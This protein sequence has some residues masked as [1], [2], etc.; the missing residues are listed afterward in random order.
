[1]AASTMS[2][3]VRPLALFLTAAA[4]A[5]VLGATELLGRRGLGPEQTRRLA[6]VAGASSVAVL[7]RFLTLAELGALAFFF[8]AL[9][10]WTRSRP[11]SS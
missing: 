5:C 10:A 2:I 7:P 6:H 9:L 3:H 1:M 11:P 4:Q 8:T